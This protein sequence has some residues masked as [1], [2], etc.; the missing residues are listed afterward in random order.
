LSSSLTGAGTAAWAASSRGSQT[1]P[2]SEAHGEQFLDGHANAT[3]AGPEGLEIRRDVH[4]GVSLKAPNVRYPDHHHPPEEIYVVLS[5]GQWRQ[6]WIRRG[7]DLA[8]E[9]FSA[10]EL[11]ET[12]LADMLTN[13]CQENSAYAKTG[14]GDHAGH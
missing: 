1:C 8:N 11:P 5:D 10:P 6:G 7:K 14:A 3:I 12:I 4:I 13:L 9:Y 2:G